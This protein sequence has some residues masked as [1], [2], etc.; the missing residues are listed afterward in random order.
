MPASVGKLFGSGRERG[1]RSL[2]VYPHFSDDQHLGGVVCASLLPPGGA[3]G[4]DPSDQ[5]D[6]GESTQLLQRW[7]CTQSCTRGFAGRTLL[8]HGRPSLYHSSDLSIRVPEESR[9][10]EQWITWA[11]HSCF[12]WRQQWTWCG[13]WKSSRQRRS[14]G[15]PGRL[16]SPLQDS[17]TIPPAPAP[18]PPSW[19]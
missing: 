5:P 13:S 4:L 9:G 6:T 12:N 11:Q 2:Q 17:A 19:G 7:A 8:H 10:G 18:T 15:F 16:S 3:G 14:V 1:R